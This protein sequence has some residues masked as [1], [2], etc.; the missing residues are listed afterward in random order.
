MGPNGSKLVQLDP[1]G[2]KWAKTDSIGCKRVCMGS[3]RSKQNGFKK[4]KQVPNR[5]NWY[6]FLLYIGQ[7]LSK[8]RMLKI[9]QK[10]SKMLK[11]GL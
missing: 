9:T 5:P 4:S 3:N 1:N 8:I 11:V 2:S 7:K 10:L 6:F